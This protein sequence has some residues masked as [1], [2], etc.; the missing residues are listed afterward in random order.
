VALAR[1]GALAVLTPSRNAS[2]P[3]VGAYQAYDT[4]LRAA[5]PAMSVSR[6]DYGRLV[7]LVRYAAAAGR[8]APEVAVEVRARLDA[9]RTRPTPPG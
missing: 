6:E 9:P 5:V 8:A 1:A 3:M 2:A 7:H 4:D